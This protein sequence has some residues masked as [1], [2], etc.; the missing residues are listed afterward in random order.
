MKYE[1][2]REAVM[3]TVIAAERLRFYSCIMDATF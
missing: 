1:F 2:R 3:P